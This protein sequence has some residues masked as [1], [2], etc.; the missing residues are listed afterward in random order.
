MLTAL[1]HWRPHVAQ[2]LLL[3]ECMPSWTALAAQFR[4]LA[5]GAPG[6]L[7]QPGAMLWLAL[8]LAGCGTT[9][10]A[11]APSGG[12]EGGAQAGD[13]AK[14]AG[15]SAHA[16]AGGANAGGFGGDKGGGQAGSGGSDK[17]P[18]A[19]ASGL[20]ICPGASAPSGQPCRSQTDCG[21]ASM[22]VAAA[23]AGASTCGA[24]FPTNH[25]C[26]SDATCGPDQICAAEANPNPCQCMGPSTSCS[27]KC[28]ADSCPASDVCGADGRCAPKSCQDGYSCLTG[29]LCDATRS[30]DAHQCAPA[31]CDFAEVSCQA[32]EVCDPSVTSPGSHCRAKRCSEG[33]TCPKNQR[34]GQTGQCER[35]TCA[36]DVDCECGACISG[37]CQDHLFMCFMPPV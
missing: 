12:S 32:D 7:A 24:C 10:G 34:C 37:T 26:S 30:G 27:P 21:A 33:A 29:T 19:G 6:L 28:K 31:R 2:S 14:D 13:A 22:C 5:A 25:A 20:P 11:G 18:S 4:R 16:G 15:G 23:P 9:S 3:F 1:P 35:L 36:S 17:T 8:S